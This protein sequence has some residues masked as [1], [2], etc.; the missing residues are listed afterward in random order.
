MCCAVVQ[1]GNRNKITITSVQPPTERSR[2]TL[3]ACSRSLVSVSF[4]LLCFS[5][6]TG[7]LSKSEIERMVADAERF[8]EED[9]KI[10]E[11]SAAKGKLETYA[12]GLKHAV[13]DSKTADKFSPTDRNT[14]MDAVRDVEKWIQEKGDTADK[15]EFEDQQNQLQSKCGSIMEA[16][17]KSGGAPGGP[18][19]DFGGQEGGAAQAGGAAGPKVEEVD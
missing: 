1:S 2:A 5:N 16:F 15:Q 7:R 6:D 3:V 9:R 19:P 13:E 11:K 12:Y 8:A 14:V 17:Y 10:Q 18:T 4:L